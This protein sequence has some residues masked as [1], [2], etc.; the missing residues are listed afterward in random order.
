MT[1]ILRLRFRRI[2]GSAVSAAIRVIKEMNYGLDHP[3]S[4]RNL[5]R[6]GDQRLPAGRVLIAPSLCC[7]AR[8]TRRL[9]PS[10]ER[11]PRHRDA[12]AE[13]CEGASRG[14]SPTAPSRAVVTFISQSSNRAT[15]PQ[16]LGG[17]Q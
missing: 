13:L 7:I 5:Y 8:G 1:N 9:G 17:S 11:R 10:L 16:P 15:H 4:R 6:P 12:V 3:D 14:C 2:L